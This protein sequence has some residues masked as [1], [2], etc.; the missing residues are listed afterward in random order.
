MNIFEKWNMI[1]Q[2]VIDVSPV[3]SFCKSHNYQTIIQI[4]SIFFLTEKV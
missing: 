3:L 4:M 1:S 2:F